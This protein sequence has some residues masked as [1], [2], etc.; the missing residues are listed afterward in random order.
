M[1]DTGKLQV[2]ARG[3]NEI[4]MTREFNAP[5]GLV[6]DAF[7]KPELLKRWLGV[8]GGWSLAVCEIDLKVGGAYR[9]VWRNTNGS[10]M[11]ASGVYREIVPGE[12]V[13]TT[14]RFD[15]AWYEGEGLGTVE[16]V[17]RDGRTTMTQTL[18]YVSK[19]ARD[20]VLKSPMEGG[21]AMSY[22]KL[23]EVLASQ[24]ATST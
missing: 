22:K 4:V 19:D 20:A 3:D 9:W 8:F 1:T 10:T 16:F 12:R 14:E 18:R 11:G 5:R 17:E 21:V 23:A 24:P 15:D 6:F 2:A 13:V 7:T